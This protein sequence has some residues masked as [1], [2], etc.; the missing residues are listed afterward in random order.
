[1]KRQAKKGWIFT[2]KTEKKREGSTWQMMNW[3]RNWK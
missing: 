3:G 2:I 1:M